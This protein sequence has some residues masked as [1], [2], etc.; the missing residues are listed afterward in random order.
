MRKEIDD[1]SGR[2][3][4]SNN[5]ALVHLDCGEWDRALSLL[6]Q[7]LAIWNQTNA[8]EEEARTLSHLGQMYIYQENWDEALVCLNRSQDA[9]ILA[10]SDDYLPELA[11]RWGEFY[12]RT[13]ELDQALDHT[14]RSVELAVEQGH[15][16]EEGFSCCVLGRVHLARGEDEPAE[17]A[18]RQSLQIFG[19]L[20]SRYQVAKTKLS[21]VRL[22]VE[23]GIVPTD[24]AR[25]YLAQATP[26]FEEL[27]AKVDLDEARDLERQL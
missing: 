27:G 10:G 4:V 3:Q 12:L 6:E 7:S 9:F 16:L 24:E 20:D 23:T 1:V 14:L 13:G 18:L 21:L 15:P 26:I 25:T 17:A 11:R 19:D 22:A 5:L 2:G 8:V